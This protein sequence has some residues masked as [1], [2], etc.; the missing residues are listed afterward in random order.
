MQVRGPQKRRQ[1]DKVAAAATL[2]EPG[3]GKILGMGQSK[4]FGY[5]K[6]ETEYNYSVNYDMGGSNYGFPTGS[7]FKPFVAA[8]L[9]V[10]LNVQITAP[11]WSGSNANTLPLFGVTTTMVR[12]LANFARIGEAPTS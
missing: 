11:R 12:P 4:P 5:G 3:T 2:V 10:R 1:P 8:V 7:T 9:S 6:N